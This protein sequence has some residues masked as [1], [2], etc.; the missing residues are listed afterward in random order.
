MKESTSQV[1]TLLGEHIYE[2]HYDDLSSIVKNRYI[3]VL[4]TEDSV[5]Y[6]VHNGE[7]TGVQYELVKKFISHLNKKL[8]IKPPLIQFE[9]IPAKKDELIPLLMEGR[10]DMIAADLT[11]YEGVFSDI[12]FLEE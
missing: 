3:R 2:K 1:T 8:K 7:P 11:A 12:V 4:T 9:M 5:N 6:F 10:G